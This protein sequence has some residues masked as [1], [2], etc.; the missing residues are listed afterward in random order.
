M[1][2]TRPATHRNRALKSPACAAL[3]LLL[4]ALC[5]ALGAEP[6]GW[7]ERIDDQGVAHGWAADSDSPGTSLWIH[8]YVEGP[9]DGRRYAGA[10]FANL[11]RGDVRRAGYEGA[12]GFRFTLPSWA[13]DGQTR[14]LSA[15]GIDPQQARNGLLNGAPKSYRVAATPPRRVEL[16]A[17]PRL[18]AGARPLV[19]RPANA[20]DFVR[21][22][23]GQPVVLARPGSSGTP[24][25][26]MA[27]HHA[28]M[29]LG[30]SP[31]SALTDG[32]HRW[33]DSE[34]AFTLYAGGQVTLAVN[35][36]TSYQG[37]FRDPSD[38]NYTKDWL[39]LYVQQQIPASATTKLRNMSE[40][41]L[42]MELRL[43][44]ANHDTGPGYNPAWHT[45]HFVFFV[46]LVDRVHNDYLWYGANLYDARGDARY[47]AASEKFDGDGT[48]NSTGKLIRQVARDQL[49]SGPLES[50]AW[51]RVGG[52]LLPDIRAT[53]QRNLANGKLR[54]A[55]D[56]FEVGTFVLG[57][58][59]PGLF[60][61]TIE[62]RELSL[63][64]TLP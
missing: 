36:N 4:A 59:V 24:T 60:V 53:L 10:V 51:V 32:G 64:A 39:H 35:S 19:T 58:E 55:I 27:Q 61:G 45:G 20:S 52:D 9:S 12:H 29:T 37:V 62:A 25:W 8:F 54:G 11:E 44:Y 50:K 5:P 18:A 14:L 41:R 43:A 42:N 3:A 6:T 22:A 46:T 30:G 38:P 34:K 16:L 21:D 7:L 31:G 2:P 13:R 28:R 23:A 33:A 47:Y 63:R 1:I 48:D 56:D 57:W 49:A 17:D 26:V 15:Y 40:L